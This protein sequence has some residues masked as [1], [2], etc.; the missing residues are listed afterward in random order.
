M[1]GNSSKFEVSS[2]L[3]TSICIVAGRS[4]NIKQDSGTAAVQQN[5]QTTSLHGIN[6]ILIDDK[7]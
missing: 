5:I 7:K 4:L 6:V 2:I 1:S 3:L